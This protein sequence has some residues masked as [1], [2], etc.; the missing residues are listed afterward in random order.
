MR[1]L[2]RYF[3]STVILTKLALL[4][5]VALHAQLGQYAYSGKKPQKKVE[6]AINPDVKQSLFSVLKELN[7]VKG[8]YF[9]FSQEGIG[10]KMVNPVA[11]TKQDVENILDAVLDNTGLEY[12]R[13][14][15]NT[16]VVITTGEKF[17]LKKDL[18]RA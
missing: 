4:L 6:Y 7:R 12:K 13:I 18:K 14:S 8:V 2:T 3:T 11:D 17:K 10:N 16:Y 9:L 1:S 5:T 15:T